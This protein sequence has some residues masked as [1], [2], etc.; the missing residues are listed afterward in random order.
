M[1]AASPA[2]KQEIN[3]FVHHTLEGMSGDKNK[4]SKRIE[5]LINALQTEKRVDVDEVLSELETLSP[6]KLASK[7]LALLNL[8]VTS[9]R[10]GL[11]GKIILN[12]E[13]DSAIYGSDNP[14]LDSSEIRTGDI[15]RLCSSVK[16]SSAKGT[17][18]NSQ[19]IETVV[20]KNTTKAVS[21]A[22]DEKFESKMM[23]LAGR[24][25]IVK[26]ANVV[27]YK[28]MDE[29][30][31]SI[32][33]IQGTLLAIARNE[34]T[35]V[36]EKAELND[37]KFFDSTL[38]PSQRD[39]VRYS[40]GS[41]VSVIHGPPGTGKTYT[42]VEIIRQLVEKGERVLV[43]GPSNI[44]VDNI[45]ERLHHVLK[46]NQLVRLGHPARLLQSNLIHSLE[47]VSRWGEFGQILRDIRDEIDLNLSKVSKTRS[48]RERRALYEE[49]KQLRREY[50]SREKTVLKNI[51]LEAKVVCATLHGSGSYSL[52]EVQKNASKPLFDTI[53]IDEVS[54]SL[55]A[56]CWIP[57]I[58]FPGTKKL[59]IAGDVLQL[60]PT[61]K[62]K[63]SKIQKLLSYTMFDLFVDQF[64]E[65]VKHLLNVQYR[66]NKKIMEFPSRE[67][68]NCKLIADDSV[69]EILLDD[70]PGVDE[71]DETTVPIIWFDTQGDDFPESIPEDESI[72]LS[73]QNDMEAALVQWYTN[74]LLNAG[75]AEADIG[76]I[77][78]YNGQVT[79]IRKLL[80]EHPN[81]EIATVDGF[82][83]REKQVIIM[84]MVRSN[85]KRE[86]GF[87]SEDR[88]TNVA[89]TRPKRQLCVIG[90]METLSGG[91]QFL[92]KWVK[93]CE[94][95][96]DIVYPDVGDFL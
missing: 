56:Q 29:T 22:V 15:V 7:G 51:Y 26:L 57:L 62:T 72:G 64:G 34:Q 44:S 2:P 52:I 81:I 45:L 21:I 71:T 37:E 50:R 85:D 42:L 4:V 73:R 69:A 46:G 6:K 23:D 79:V 1:H 3:L 8:V 66:M 17:D 30:L 68:Y 90:D 91:S 32:A 43:C 49:V 19:G 9:M 95:N 35:P 74:K 83:G 13:P 28:R 87:L 86:V 5:T 93:W 47:I 70:L 38:N 78:P 39:A 84:S 80:R 14:K 63:D 48:G 94:E 75:V 92:K 96:A 27:T 16:G 82:Q 65:R 41:Q 54:Q 20:L 58:N 36:I 60:P 24:V 12:L 88:R 33:R 31:K 61:I 59:V 10:T 55:E 89:I 40:L 11:G 25:W 76:V 18:E 53:I 67:F 77:S